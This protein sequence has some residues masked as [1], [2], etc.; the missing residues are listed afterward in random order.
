M[1]QFKNVSQRRRRGFT[2]TEA[3]IVLGIVG[4]V[5]AAVWVAA[6]A[7][8][9]NMRISQATQ[10]ILMIAQAVRSMHATQ[11]SITMTTADAVNAGIIPKDM[12]DNASCATPRNP[13]R[14]GVIVQ[15][16][17][18]DAFDII[19]SGLPTSACV[20]LL[21]RNTGQGRDSGM[22]GAVGASSGNA[23]GSTTTSFPV[24]I[25]TASGQCGTGVT[26]A[27]VAFTFRLRN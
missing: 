23:T 3:A 5:L 26:T 14:G 22:V 20:D 2:L 8:Y 21:T 18:T 13:W 4:L 27:S 9:N 24:A 15:N 16:N 11:T 7:V 6:S 10:Q 17:G 25:G 1:T 19:Y 12:C